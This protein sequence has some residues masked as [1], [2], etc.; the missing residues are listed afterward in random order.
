MGHSNP[1]MDSFGAALGIHRS[2][3]DL[4]ARRPISFS[5]AYNST[6]GRSRTGCQGDGAE[7]EF[8][9]SGQGPGAGRR[10]RSLAVSWWTRHS[11]TLVESLELLEKINR[12]VV[13][14]HHRRTEGDLP[15][16]LLSYM[17][18]YASSASELVSEIVQYACEKKALSKAGGRR[19]ARGHNG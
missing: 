19:T 8:L 16:V 3:Q 13:I 4:S 17:E 14:D 12:T 1:D 9:D 10:A 2:S 11:P 7:Y 18:S 6:H 5:T 15:N